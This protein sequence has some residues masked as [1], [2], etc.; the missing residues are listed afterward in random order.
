MRNARCMVR[1]DFEL[2][3]ER[4]IIGLFGWSIYRAKYS[5]ET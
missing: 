1:S 3:F 2:F 4:R 5:K